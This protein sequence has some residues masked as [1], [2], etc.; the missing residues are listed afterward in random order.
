MVP[1]ARPRGLLFVLRHLAWG[2]DEA[3]FLPVVGQIRVRGHITLYFESS[4]CN[5]HLRWR[6]Q[7]WYP[8]LDQQPFQYSCVQDGRKPHNIG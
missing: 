8:K 6:F 7:V 4:I 1:E 3:P 5:S 2:K